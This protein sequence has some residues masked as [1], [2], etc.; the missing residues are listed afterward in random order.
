MA[1]LRS[2][3]AHGSAAHGKRAGVGVAQNVEGG[4]WVDLGA[5]RSLSEASLLM[6]DAPWFLVGASKDQLVGGASNREPFEQFNA[7]RIE[8]NVPWLARLGMPDRDPAGTG[9]EVS[10]AHAR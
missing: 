4:E 6:G 9:S 2:D 1:K 10:G 8:R 7:F 5:P 3:D